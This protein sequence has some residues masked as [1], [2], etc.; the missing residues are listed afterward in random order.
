[1]RSLSSIF[2]ATLLL[3]LV[4]ANAWSQTSCELIL[5]LANLAAPGEVVDHKTDTSDVVKR[6]VTNELTCSRGPASCP[7]A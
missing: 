1:M 3:A 2:G 5:S 6:S 4:S 7:A